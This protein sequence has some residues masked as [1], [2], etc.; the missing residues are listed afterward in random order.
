MRPPIILLVAKGSARHQK[1][2]HLFTFFRLEMR[3]LFSKTPHF[4][5]EPILTLS[6]NAVSRIEEEAILGGRNGN[7]PP[8]FLL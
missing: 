8:N 3:F 4:Y 6:K 7:F 2:T 1:P 5:S